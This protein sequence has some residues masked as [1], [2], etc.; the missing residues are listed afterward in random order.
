M[1]R[2]KL[3]QAHYLNIT[4]TKWEY[5]ETDRITGKP[6]RIQFDVPTLL[7]PDEPTSWNAN[8]IRNPRGELLGGDIIVAYED[9]QH[10]SA[11]YIFSGAPTP[12]MEPIDAE[13]EAISAKHSK[14]WER[15]PETAG[16]SYADALVVAMQQKFDKMQSSPSAVQVEGLTEMLTM[17]TQV[18]KQNQDMMMMFMGKQMGLA[19]PEHG[20]PL[21]PPPPAEE[22]SREKVARRA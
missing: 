19:R 8:F 22:A 20:E 9:G 2:W 16:G 13:A 12:E 5:S 21:P 15:P 3:N 18:I 14:A 7:H 6:K 4:G 11:D 17:M 1:A 10:E